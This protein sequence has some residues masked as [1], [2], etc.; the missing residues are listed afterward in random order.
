MKTR[1]TTV[2]LCAVIT[3]LRESLLGM[4]V[5]NVYDID[6]KTYLIRLGKTEV[7]VML[8]VESGNRINTT[9]FEWPKN[10]MPSGFSMK[11]R[12]HIRSRRLVSIRQLGIDRIV[13]LQFGSDEA[14]YHLIIELYDRGNIVL[15]DYEYTILN[16]LRPRT[17]NEDVRF[18]VRE[19]YPVNSTRQREPL[20]S[21]ERLR[22]ILAESKEGM[23]LKKVLNPHVVYGAALLEHCLIDEGFPENAKIGKGFNLEGDLPKVMEALK[24]AEIFLDLTLSEKCQGVIVQ[25]ENKS[26]Q[27]I[28]MTMEFKMSYSRIK[29]FTRSY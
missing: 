6:N 19:K 15:T 11:C 3:E 21:L 5:A 29:N 20:M 27:A 23:E 28:E 26:P 13:D 25:K 24:K 1:F 10:L 8:L 22:E 14:A 18:A 9:D 12:K 16:L 2:D 4:R 17:D 7:K